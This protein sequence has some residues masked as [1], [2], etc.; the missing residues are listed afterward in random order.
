[1]APLV[2][3]LLQCRGQSR[4]I[5]TDKYLSYGDRFG[6]TLTYTGKVDMWL[7]HKSFREYMTPRLLLVRSLSFDDNN[8]VG[9]YITRIFYHLFEFTP[10]KKDHFVIGD[11][12]GKLFQL[13]MFIDNKI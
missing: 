2:V 1:M 10:L 5:Y 8:D 7:F 3:A 11:K 4:F 13:P 6:D 9:E 12:H